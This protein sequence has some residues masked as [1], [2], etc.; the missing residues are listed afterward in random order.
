VTRSPLAVEGGPSVRTR[1]WPAWPLVTD[2]T[3]EALLDVLHSGRWT[4]SG[5]FLGNEPYERRFADAFARFHDVPY[6]VPT[7][8]GSSALAVALE[9]LGVSPGDEVLVPGLTWRACSSA[10]AAV[11]AAP[12]LVDVEGDTL[13][14]SVAAAEAAMSARTKAIMI[15][16]LHC[17]AA[18]LDGFTALADSYGVPLL[19]DCSQ[20]HGA[21]WRGKR[22]GSFGAIAAFSFQQTKLLT[23]G[24]GGAALT[25]DPVLYD[26]MQ[27]LRADGRRYA[28]HPE[29]GRVALEECGSSQGRN[30]CMSEFHAALLLDGLARLDDENRVR[31]A[32]VARLA[33]ALKGSGLAQPIEVPAGLDEVAY[34]RLCLR[35]DLQAY[36]DPEIEWV[37]SA[38]AA[39][40]RLA[41]APV[42]RP[43]DQS[44][45][46]QP[47]K[48]PTARGDRLG[49][50]D[51]KRFDLPR[52]MRASRTC[53]T[54]P[55]HVLLGDATDMED[56]AAALAKVR[57]YAPARGSW[58]RR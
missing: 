18:D 51:P 44:A 17:S 38:L 57:R 5:P 25:S 34:S 29:V 35:L 14:M 13:C 31:R 55:H 46:Y 23:S 37:A 1:D 53:L 39:E 50:L 48:S 54:I 43:L 26:R 15:V 47:L 22:V 20:A 45:L 36:G 11:G 7:S 21:R 52:A 8:N 56:I 42:V 10:V 33:E 3:K 4:L 58:L 49:A 30:H 24:E 6:C 19:E 2:A 16:H 9:A 40:L 41:V 12:V 27:Q 32:N 28:A